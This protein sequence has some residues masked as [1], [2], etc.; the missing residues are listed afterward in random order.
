M[1]I[2]QA[3]V[4]DKI[5]V[6]LF[7]ESYVIDISGIVVSEETGKPASGIQ[8]RISSMDG[9]NS[10][11]GGIISAFNAFSDKDG[12]FF[13]QVSRRN[14]YRLTFSDRNMIFQTI[15]IS[16]TADETADVVKVHLVPR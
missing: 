1:D 4:E 11:I 8:V 10:S 3:E 15:S 2:T 5:K 9:T 13:I 16:V 7:R 12:Q 14:S 6:S